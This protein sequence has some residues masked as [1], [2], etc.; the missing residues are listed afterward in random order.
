MDSICNPVTSTLMET[1]SELYG[2]NLHTFVH[3]ATL[4]NFN[5]YED[6]FQIPNIYQAFVEACPS[7]R[8]FVSGVEMPAMTVL[9]ICAVRSFDSLLIDGEQLIFSLEEDLDLGF[10]LA[11]IPMC[12]EDLEEAVTD[13]LGRSWTTM[14]SPQFNSAVSKYL[15]LS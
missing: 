1:I 12:L 6:V 15:E 13:S 4:W 11:G 7:L 2:K 9:L 5:P 3:A 14:N 8:T 10:M